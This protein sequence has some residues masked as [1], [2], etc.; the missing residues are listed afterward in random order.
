M[1]PR[2]AFG[3]SVSGNGKTA[4]HL[5]KPTDVIDADNAFHLWYGDT[6]AAIAIVIRNT[7]ST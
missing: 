3:Q 2:E 7:L 1:S 6:D 4:A 5:Q